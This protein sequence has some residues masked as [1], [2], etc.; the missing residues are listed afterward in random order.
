[1]VI[2]KYLKEGEISPEEEEILK[3]QIVDTLKIVGVVIP[4]AL[5][6]GSAILMPLLIKVAEKNNI[7]LM[8]TAFQS[9]KK[10]SDKIELEKIPKKKSS[11]SWWKK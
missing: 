1:M 10:V 11:F 5:I 7:E 2:E 3:I 9:E 6:P 4:F 8:P